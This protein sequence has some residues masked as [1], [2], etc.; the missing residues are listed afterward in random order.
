MKKSY[1]YAACAILLWST[2]PTISKLLLSEMDSYTVLCVSSLC[3][4]VT[5]VIINLCSGKWSIIKSYRFTDYLKMA[6]IGA[7]GVFIYYVLYY[8]GTTRMLASQ[9]F[10]INYLWPIMSIVFACIL[11]RERLTVRKTIAV[12]MSFMGVFTVAGG[13]LLRFDANV[14]VG[15]LCCFGAAVCYGLFTALTKKSHYDT[16]IVMTISMI[17]AFVGSLTL[18]WLRGDSIA[19]MPTQIPGILWNGACAMALANLSWAL[20]LS[21]GNTAKVSNFA[22]ITPFLSLVWTFFILG[23]PI[24]P[25]SVIGLCLIVVGIFVQLKDHKQSADNTPLKSDTHAEQS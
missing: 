24:K 18:I 12:V 11:L 3:A 14:A 20:A 19:I 13:D 9:A 6:A 15:M 22:Y 21:A 7:P 5:L 25:L 4:A 10:I 2:L 17:T 23:E 1:L 8:E 16:Q